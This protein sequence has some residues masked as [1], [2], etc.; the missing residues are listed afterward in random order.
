MTDARTT[1]RFVGR[2][3]VLGPVVGAV[4]AIVGAAL[5]L[6]FLSGRAGG[7]AETLTVTFGG[8]DAGLV[9]GSPGAGLVWSFLPPFALVAMLLTWWAAPLLW[10]WDDR[11]A[12]R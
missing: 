4:T 3:L 7:L 1:A 6:P 9:P 10:P 11:L 12:A 5:I 8:D 2:G